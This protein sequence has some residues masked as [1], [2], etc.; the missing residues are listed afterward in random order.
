[1]ASYLII[2][3]LL[4][5]LLLLLTIWS[6]IKLRILKSNKEQIGMFGKQFL[7][8][9]GAL[10]ISV[11]ILEMGIVE[12][13]NENVLFDFVDDSFLEWLIYPVVLVILAKL[14]QRGEGK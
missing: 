12:T 13:I 7:F 8:S 11:L 3:G 9:L 14:G 2:W 1:M 5:F 10:I 4:P 6:W